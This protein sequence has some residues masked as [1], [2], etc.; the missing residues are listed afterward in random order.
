MSRSRNSYIRALRSVTFHADRHVLADLVGRDRLAGTGDHRLLAGNPGKLLRRRVD[1]LAV[2]DRLADAHVE[3]DLFEGR[4]LHHIAVGELLHELL[5]HL[6]EILLL[7]PRNIALSHRSPPRAFGHPD[8][9]SVAQELVADP[10]RLAVLG[11]DDGQIR[12]VDRQLLG[13]DAALLC[14]RLLLMPPGH[15]HA[16][17]HRPVVARE[18]LEDIAR[19]PLS[20]P[21][22]TTTRSPFSDLEPAITAPQARAR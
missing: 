11:I 2:A 13:D 12:N 16:L 18:H 1:D 6:V 14:R 7:Q 21:V 20:L 3:D 8:L 10:C 5:A 9:L 19:L 15:I 4:H 17:H 22:S